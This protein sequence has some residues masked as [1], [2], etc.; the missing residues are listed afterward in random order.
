MMETD[1]KRYHISEWAL[2]RSNFQRLLPYVPIVDLYDGLLS[3]LNGYL[4]ID[5][6]TLNKRLENMYPEESEHMSMKEI[7]MKHY[8]LEAMQLIESAL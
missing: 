6:V 3:V 2:F 8:G 1:V 7:I 4:S 5:L